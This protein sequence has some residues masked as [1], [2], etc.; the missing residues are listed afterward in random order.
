MKI[1]DERDEAYVI[2][3][4]DGL[5]ASEVFFCVVGLFLYNHY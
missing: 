5:T 2:G 3:C 4:E 1:A